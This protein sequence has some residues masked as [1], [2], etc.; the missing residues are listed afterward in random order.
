MAGLDVEKLLAP[1]SDGS[2]CGANL[3]HKPPY[4]ELDRLAFG[5]PEQTMGSSTIPAVEPNWKDLRERC[6]EL[7]GQTRDLRVL[8]YLTLALLQLEGFPGLRNGLLLLKRSI[9]QFWDCLYPQ[10]DPDDNNDPLERMNILRT[11]ASRDLVTGDSPGLRLLRQTPLTNSR[12][13]GRFSLR[14]IQV[15]SGV[16]PPADPEAPKLQMSLIEAA[17]KDTSVE[18]LQAAHDAAREATT[19]AK[20]LETVLD[21]KVGAGKGVDL[22]DLGRTLKEIGDH[23]GKFLSM[24]GVGVAPSEAAPGEDGGGAM[25]GGAA[26]G[27]RTPITGEIQSTQDVVRMIDKMCDF[28]AR[29]EPSSPVPI[30]LRRAQRLV[31]KNFWDILNDLSPSAVDTVKVISG[32]EGAPAAT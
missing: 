21:A 20:E 17:A 6:L 11:F 5:T 10:L 7:L 31:G 3:E 18:F 13:A 26:A 29:S 2:P 4:M 8:T 23:L 32:T 27:T 14:D 30:I 1:V 25:T 9:E 12:Q 22:R 24:H 28:Y 16:I 19:L 15:A